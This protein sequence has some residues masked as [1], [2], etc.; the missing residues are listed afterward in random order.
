MEVFEAYDRRCFWKSYLS[1]ILKVLF[2]CFLLNEI[3][4]S[5]V[6]KAF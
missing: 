5:Q 6:E 4:D 1:Q 2:E 3:F